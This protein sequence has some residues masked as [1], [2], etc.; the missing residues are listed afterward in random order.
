MLPPDQ[1]PLIQLVTQWW[2]EEFLPNAFQAR[3][4]RKLLFQAALDEMTAAEKAEQPHF[5]PITNPVFQWAVQYLEKADRT[6]KH[7]DP[8][9]IACAHLY[10]EPAPF[11]R[12]EIQDDDRWEEAKTEDFKTQ[13]TR[14]EPR[15]TRPTLP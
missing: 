6:R 4:R 8:A 11:C 14:S 3:G 1:S 9:I 13:D 10:L 2:R 12:T 15:W 7:I 5:D